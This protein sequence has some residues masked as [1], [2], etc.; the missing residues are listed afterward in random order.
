MPHLR[1]IAELLDKRLQAWRSI[2]VH[3][4]TQSSNLMRERSVPSIEQ[5]LDQLLNQ[6]LHVSGDYAI[7]QSAVISDVL[8]A[9]GRL[10]D[11]L[12]AIEQSWPSRK[13]WCERRRR[14]SST[15]RILGE[16]VLVAEI[17][18]IATPNAYQRLPTIS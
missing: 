4:D 18:E 1:K 6:T 15:S 7:R 13:S 12:E 2:V 9:R 8:T 10:L 16:V 5:N 11:M 3:S 17:A 14:N